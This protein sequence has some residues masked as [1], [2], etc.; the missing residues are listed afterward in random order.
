MNTRPREVIILY[1]N[2]EITNIEIAP[3]VGSR[4]YGDIIFHRRRIVDHIT[5]RLPAWA[6]DSLCL[7][8][9]ADELRELRGRL[10]QSDGNTACFVVSSRAGISELDKW[11]QLVE[12]LPY[13]EE[14]F[15][16]L[17]HNPLLCFF[18]DSKS[19]LARWP[20]LLAAPLHT[21]ETPWDEAEKLLTLRPLDLGRVED[22][23]G[24]IAGSTEA[25][26]FNAMTIGDYYYTKSSKDKAK[27]EAEY[28]FY[29]LAPENMRS[30]LVQP[31]DLHMDGDTASYRMLRYHLADAA[32]QWVHNAFNRESFSLFI[33][34]LLFFIGERAQQT[35]DR[36]VA[37]DA[38]EQ[39]FVRK[40]EDRHAAFMAM[41]QGKQ[42]NTLVTS[43]NPRLDVATQ[44]QRFKTLFEKF[45]K[46]FAKPQLAI[47]HGDP[48][49]SNILY[50]QQRYILKLIDPK[51]AKDE[52]ALWTHPLYD[53]CKISH[54]VLGDYDFINNGLFELRLD[55]TNSLELLINGADNREHKA[56]FLKKLADFG[57]DWRLVRLGE[58]SLFLSMLPLH[59]DYPKKVTAFILT[60]NR[61]LDELD[62]A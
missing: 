38:A 43:A 5:D 8:N 11:Y 51:G 41:P 58:A 29:Q 18:K 3:F 59:I 42:I 34:R 13:A 30:W 4:G 44:I 25:R 37:A 47:G 2:R 22:F 17:R 61:I 46:E 10:E 40:L 49:F 23:L 53:L 16:N 28:R 31:F 27:I 36:T 15:T 1:D 14:D 9:S 50:D 57:Y 54:S 33:E 32:L 21:W 24:Y 52:S 26:H 48:C 56:L 35:C 62:N 55:E 60:A 7:I 45:S 20:E 12:R 39:L 6:R 19:L